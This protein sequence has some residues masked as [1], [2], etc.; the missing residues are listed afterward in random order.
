M[1]KN[2]SKIKII[3]YNQKYKINYKELN[4]EWLNTYFSIEPIDEKILSNPEEEVLNNNGFIFFALL[5][6]KAIGTFTLMKLD[7]NTFE[8]SKMCV[9][10][11]YQGQGIGEKLL[12]E[13]INFAVK[14]GAITITLFTNNK[15]ES[16]VNL[17]KKKGFKKVKN[18]RNQKNKTFKRESTYMSL[19]LNK[20][21]NG[22]IK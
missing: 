10:P 16:A 19:V 7:K 20:Y 6:E 15:L 4:T 9:R 12:E 17:Y 13:A 5:N 18:P 3:H 2:P 22:K 11:S 8:L 21:Y 14:E 1:K